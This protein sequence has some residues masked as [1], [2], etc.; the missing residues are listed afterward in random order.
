MLADTHQF[1]SFSLQQQESITS[2]CNIVSYTFTIAIQKL[3]NFFPLKCHNDFDSE[4]SLHATMNINSCSLPEATERYLLKFP[5]C[6]WYFLKSYT[7]ILL[8]I[9]RRV[10]I[11]RDKK[12]QIIYENQNYKQFAVYTWLLVF[13]KQ[14]TKY[15]IWLLFLEW[16]RIGTSL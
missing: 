1:S 16:E 14:I 7:H 8:T 2:W 9:L 13:R 3:W 5:L 12:I 15:K 10:S 11:L 6:P 4:N